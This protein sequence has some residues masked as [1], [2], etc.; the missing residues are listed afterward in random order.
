MNVYDMPL[1]R[2]SLSLN[3]ENPTNTENHPKKYEQYSNHCATYSSRQQIPEKNRDMPFLK[4]S[5][6]PYTPQPHSK[7][8]NKKQLKLDTFLV[9]QEY[10]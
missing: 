8:I 4:T 6:N 9:E 1:K 5:N 7:K 2:S 10:Q 3:Y